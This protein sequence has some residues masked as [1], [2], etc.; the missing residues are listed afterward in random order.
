MRKTMSAQPR[1][2]SRWGAEDQRGTLNYITPEKIRRATQTVRRGKAYSL[3][4]PLQ[5]DA[6]IWPTR[7]RNWHITTHYNCAGPGSG[8]AEDVLIMHTHGTTHIDALCHVFRDGLMY[9]GFPAEKMISS[10]GALRNG[11][12]NVDAITTRGVLID[13]AAYHGVEVLEAGH[14]ITPE[15]VDAIALRQS[16]AIERGDALLFRTGFMKVWGQ[17]VAE[18]DRAQPG[19]TLATAEWAG[20]KEIVLLGADNSAVETFTEDVQLPVHDEFIRNQGGYLM[21]L[22]NLDELAADRI[23]EFLLIVAPLRITNGLG[24]PLNP[25]ALA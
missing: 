17:N 13:V 9:N 21:E 7:H 3:A 18:F 11:I 2:W 16:V 22:L 15:E 6:P 24:S 1:N 20:A 19:I 23:Y 10:E 8:E 25:I 5:A 4:I 14:A 12:C